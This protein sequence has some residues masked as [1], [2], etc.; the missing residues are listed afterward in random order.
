MHI[1]KTTAVR[2]LAAMLAAVTLAGCTE[3]DYPDISSAQGEGTTAVQESSVPEANIVTESTAKEYKLNKS[4]FSYTL[5]AEKIPDTKLISDSKKYSGDGYI[6]VGAYTQASF[7]L[8]VS[9]TQ[10]YDISISALS[11]E[12]G[13]IT[14]TIDGEKQINSENGVYKRINGELYGAYNVVQSDT[15]ESISLC[16]VYLTQ[17]KHKV[18]LQTVKNTV[19]IDKITV[20]NTERASDKR[21]SDAGT[22]ISGKDVNTERIALMDYFKRIYGKKTL[23]AQNVTPNTNTEIDTIVRNTGRFPAIRVSDL[24][25]YTASGSKLVK[26]NIDIQLAQEWAKNGGI[27]S[28]TWYWYT[29]IGKTTFYL[30]ESSFDVDSVMSDYEDLA[31]M[32]EESLAL[33]LKD[34]TISE[35]CYAVLSDMDAVAKQ[36][37]VLKDSGVT[38]LFTPLPTDNAGWYW[39]EK[40][41]KTYKWLWQTMHRR[42]DELYGLSNLLWVYTADVDPQMFP[43]DDYVDIIGCD[44]YD[45]TDTAHLAAMYA[46]DA[47]SLNKRMLALTEC[48]KAPDPD[49]MARD[50]AVWLWAAPWNGKYLINEKGELT[51]DYMSVDEL[52]KFYNHEAT[53]TRDEIKT[54]TE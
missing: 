27:V 48:A 15:F 53:V 46:T 51:G 10:F 37:S 8:D 30:D 11:K 18:T 12:G 13:S 22:W 19:S 50:N 45:N 34:E 9:S 5:E 47:L 17:G 44:V 42:F 28:Y 24:R 7:E 38:V 2:T 23:T 26:S 39:W 49:I 1:K 40:N 29:P 41:S 21:Y 33:L 52:K 25:Y 35:E 4:A 20:K 16:P 43:G 54:E 36:L 31:V 14:L 3:I 6:T 32:N